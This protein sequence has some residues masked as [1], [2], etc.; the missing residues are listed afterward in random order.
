MKT[1]NTTVADTTDVAAPT[2]A[3]PVVPAPPTKMDK[4]KVLYAG[5][6]DGSI[7]LIEGKSARATFI[8]QAQEADIGMTKAG[9]ATY[10]QNLESAAKGGKLYPHTA[11]KKKDEAKPADAAPAAEQ[12]ESEAPADETP[13][14][15]VKDENDVSHLE[16]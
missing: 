8:A 11:A 10:W 3:A 7:A 2:V 14:D 5:L 1:E 13:A 6:K 4:A 12:V 16:G 15:D 9:A